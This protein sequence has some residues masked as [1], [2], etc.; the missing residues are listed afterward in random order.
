M[1]VRFALAIGGLT[2]VVTGVAVLS[3]ETCRSV[4]WGQGGSD[5]A[6]RFSATCADVLT[7]GGMAQSTAGAIAIAAGLAMV[8]AV[9]VDLVTAK[10]RSHTSLPDSR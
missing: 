8:F 10:Y 4:I 3:S 2:L 1:I 6:G 7:D 5:R 9:T